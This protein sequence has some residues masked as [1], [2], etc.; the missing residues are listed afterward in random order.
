MNLR[1]PKL[2]ALLQSLFYGFVTIAVPILI[3]AL[4]AGGA[5]YG[6]FAPGVTVALL[7]VLNL[8]ENNI[9]ASTGKALFGT[10]G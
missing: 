5:L 2:V 3:T 6:I 9:Q 8:L 10:I 1:N 7:W 4:G